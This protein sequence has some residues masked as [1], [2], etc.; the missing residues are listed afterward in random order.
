VK[1][2]A[3]KLIAA[4]LNLILISYIVRELPNSLTEQYLLALAYIG[5]ASLVVGLGVDTTLERYALRLLSQWPESIL[6][7]VVA[8]SSCVRMALL[9]SG[10]VI[11]DAV[12]PNTIEV[13]SESLVLALATF[14]F[15]SFSSLLNGVLLYT[16]SAGSNVLRAVARFMILFLP[17]DAVSL[18]NLLK[19]E[20]FASLI[21][22]LFC[23][24]VFLSYKP[25]GTA[26]LVQ[27]D[28]V[29][30]F[31]GWNWAARLLLN[32]LSLNTLKILVLRSG[33]PYAVLIAYII[34]LTEAV[35]KFL[36]SLVLAGKYRPSLAKKYDEGR[37]KDLSTN[38]RALGFKSFAI[39]AAIALAQLA[40]LPA[41]LFY[42]QNANPREFL[43]LIFLCGGWLFLNNIKFSINAISNIL[44]INHIPFWASGILCVLFFSGLR[45]L[46]ITSPVSIFSYLALLTLSYPLLWIGMSH[47]YLSRLRAEA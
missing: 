17:A 34:Q 3:L 5:L 22:A 40:F 23:L 10:L 20:I 4:A 30:K 26:K 11:L 13:N 35:E 29:V 33:H 7:S 9:I 12:F 46:S 1:I 14:L 37:L 45:L 32:L 28:I 42:L 36:P 19:V 24:S 41:A 25:K 6:V 16:E 47:R 39:G 43:A 21:S 27:S 18:E 44:E 31:M 38:L 2:Y 15:T 8:L